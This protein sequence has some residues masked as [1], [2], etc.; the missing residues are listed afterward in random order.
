MDPQFLCTLH[1]CNKPNQTELINPDLKDGAKPRSNSQVALRKS[2]DR[3]HGKSVGQVL[4]T[5]V[6]VVLNSCREGR[7]ILDRL[8][9]GLDP[10]GR[11]EA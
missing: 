2:G 6:G 1:R 9:E 10:N 4:N 11:S 3:S 7:L 8:S 5:P